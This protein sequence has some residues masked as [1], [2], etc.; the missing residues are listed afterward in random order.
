MS[1]IYLSVANFWTGTTVKLDGSLFP[2]FIRVTGFLEQSIV[3]K[4]ARLAIFFNNV[5]LI[6]IFQLTPFN[7]GTSPEGK[8]YVSCSSTLNRK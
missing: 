1:N 3:D 6:L 7:E 8:Q 2:A 5:Y 4:A